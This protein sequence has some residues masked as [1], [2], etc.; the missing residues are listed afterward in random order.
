[1]LWE[2]LGVPYQEQSYVANN[3]FAVVNV[4]NYI[5]IVTHSIFLQSIKSKVST[6]QTLIEQR[7]EL[8]KK[9]NDVIEMIKTEANGGKDGDASA[10]VAYAINDNSETEVSETISHIYKSCLFY[11]PRMQ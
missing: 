7:N 10:T 9:I 4:Q 3:F 5:Q 1:M 11:R 2:E 8:L 6:I